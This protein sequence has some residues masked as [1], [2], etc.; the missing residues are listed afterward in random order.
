MTKK[1]TPTITSL[2]T[3]IRLAKNRGSIYISKSPIKYGLNFIDKN[4][5][6]P[7]KNSQVVAYHYGHD[8]GNGIYHRHHHQAASAQNL[9]THT[10]WSISVIS[11]LSEVDTEETNQYGSKTSFI[12][13]QFI[14]E[15]INELR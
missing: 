14:S 8:H 1:K 10:S 12:T 3:F 13:P 9:G 4:I 5:A 11:F 2:N 15:F 6:P 7:A